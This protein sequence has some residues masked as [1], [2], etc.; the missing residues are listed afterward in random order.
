MSAYDPFP[1]LR[2]AAANVP[3]GLKC[4]YKVHSRVLDPQVPFVR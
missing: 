3:L 4:G 1:T 2:L